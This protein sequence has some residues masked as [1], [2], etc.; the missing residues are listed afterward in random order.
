MK[1]SIQPKKL[2]PKAFQTETRRKHN[3]AAEHTKTYVSSE[4]SLQQS[5]SLK[6]EGDSI[7]APAT[8]AGRGGISIIRISGPDVKKIAAQILGSVPKPRHAKL[9]NFLDSE[10]K[11]ID[12]GLALYFPAPNSFT[13]EDVLELHGHGGPVV[14]DLL[15]QRILELGVKLARPGE[16]T[17]RAFLNGK[18]DLTQAEATV[19]LINANSNQAAHSAL[20]SLQG[21]FSQ[22]INQ[23]LAALTKLRV[24]I[25]AAIDFTEE[26][27]DYL[28]KNEIAK[29]FADLLAHLN[30]IKHEAQQGSLLREG[31]SV[32]I[33]GKPNVGKSSLLNYLCGHD[34]A[35]VT[36]VAGTT[37]DVLK[38]YINLDGLPLHIIDTAGLRVSTDLIE[39]EGIKRAWHE[40]EKSNFILLLID[41]D[42]LD[43]KPYAKFSEKLIIVRNKIDLI[44][45]TLK[46]NIIPIS[47]KTGAGIA[48]LKKHIQTK[49][50]F[51]NTAEGKFSA[52]RRHLDALDKTEQF[53]LTA[54]QHCSKNAALEIT[55]EE[56]RQAQNA[57]GEITG[58]FYSEDLLGKIFSEFCVG[59]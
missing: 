36:P 4:I 16:F 28:S 41:N 59:K 54:Q 29:Q 34:S 56:L 27:I 24:Y 43:L 42:E 57:L 21:N 18:I 5:I 3:R 33:A 22:Q 52:R 50:G 53:L 25:E 17:E 40:L 26:E 39:A 19:D 37:R 47:V 2:I 14:Q 35:I 30:K 15:L 11:I 10:Q 20:Q 32:V 49:A 46:Q 7:V 6:S 12:Q 9:V 45:T 48:Q 44:P 31:I 55:A 38:E 58:A 13:G 1:K 51:N 23:L 8:P